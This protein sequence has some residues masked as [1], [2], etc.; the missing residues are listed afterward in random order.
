MIAYQRLNR[1]RIEN[2]ARIDCL[3][4]ERVHQQS[5]QWSAEPIVGRDI[6]P[7]FLPRQHRFR[8]LAAHQFLEN[9]L[10][11]ESADLQVIRQRRRKIH[12]PRIEKWR[13]YLER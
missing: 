8:E 3:A 2:A 12:D 11:L 1:G 9:K 10:L 7:G 4:R 5:A 6:E 13:P